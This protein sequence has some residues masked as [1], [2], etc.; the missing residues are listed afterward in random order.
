MDREVAAPA[1]KEASRTAAGKLSQFFASAGD[2]SR[3]ARTLL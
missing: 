1:K 3:V 2:L